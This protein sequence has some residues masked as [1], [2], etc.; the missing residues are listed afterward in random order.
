VDPSTGV[1]LVGSIQQTL[2]QG[3]AQ[4]WSVLAVPDSGKQSPGRLDHDCFVRSG[5]IVEEF[6]VEVNEDSSFSSLSFSQTDKTVVAE[7][8]TVLEEYHS[9]S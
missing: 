3:D 2:A 4:C 9:G 1:K 6:N 7:L 5:D 8:R